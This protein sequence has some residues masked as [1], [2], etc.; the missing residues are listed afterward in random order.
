[1]GASLRVKERHCPVLV[2]E[3]PTHDPWP[4]SEMQQL[5]LS[6]TRPVLSAPPQTDG[7]IAVLWTQGDHTLPAHRLASHSHI[8]RSLVSNIHLPVVP[9][10]GETLCNK[11]MDSCHEGGGALQE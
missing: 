7:P 2:V 3:E 9:T 6:R 1:M 4:L 8:P 5:G 11:K 10:G